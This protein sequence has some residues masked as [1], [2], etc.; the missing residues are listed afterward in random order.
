MCVCVC[1]CVYLALYTVYSG[2]FWRGL[3][4]VFFSPFAKIKPPFSFAM[5]MLNDLRLPII[6][7]ISNSPTSKNQHLDLSEC[8]ELIYSKDFVRLYIFYYG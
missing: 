4:L 7:Q 6:C 1:V 3:G 2:C 8:I 5:H